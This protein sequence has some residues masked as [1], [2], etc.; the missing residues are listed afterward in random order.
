MSTRESRTNKTYQFRLLTEDIHFG[1]LHHNMNFVNYS[2]WNLVVLNLKLANVT[3][4][5]SFNYEPLT[6]YGNLS[7]IGMYSELAY[8]NDMLLRHGDNGNVQTEVLLQ[9]D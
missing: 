5:F 3:Q 9:K 6:I 2:Q 1:V 8:Y 4:L 7:D